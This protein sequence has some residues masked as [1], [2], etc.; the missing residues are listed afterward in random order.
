MTY[1]PWIAGGAALGLAAVGR[2]A[3]G[4]GD[5]ST[6]ELVLAWFALWKREGGY[7]GKIR[8][9]D[10]IADKERLTAAIHAAATN[11]GWAHG[12]LPP[13]R[14]TYGEPM[15][16]PVF[17]A[18]TPVGQVSVHVPRAS[19]SAEGWRFPPAIEKYARKGHAIPTYSGTWDRSRKTPERVARLAA[20]GVLSWRPVAW[21][22]SRDQWER[23]AAKQALIQ[24]GVPPVEAA[25]R[26]YLETHLKFHRRRAASADTSSQRR[27]A[28]K[29]VAK[30]ERDL[31]STGQRATRRLG[32]NEVVRMLRR[33][34]A[35]HGIY[36]LQQGEAPGSV[37][38]HL[39]GD[40][41]DDVTAPWN[42]PWTSE[43][44]DGRVVRKAGWELVGDKIRISDH[45]QPRGGGYSMGRGER[46]GYTEWSI[47][48]STTLQGYP[49]RTQQQRID[50]I[51]EESVEALQDARDEA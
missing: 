33:R 43:Y 50:E 38:L 41:Y 4:G 6:E 7:M 44:D 9:D 45:R 12:F 29:I 47:D 3:E 18:D 8:S 31:A 10:S 16:L 39:Y 32:H 21:T 20:T 49:R 17:Y 13:P 46:H 51:V 30:L 42:P 1:F 40:V 48:P 25:R 24:Q 36:A 22:P 37:Y 19:E 11:Q 35:K 5:P 26:A 28:R 2:R 23:Q 15:D 27:K 14:N 34:L